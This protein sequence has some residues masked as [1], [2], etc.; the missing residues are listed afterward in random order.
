VRFAVHWP[1]NPV[2][3]PR[4]HGVPRRDVPSRVHIRIACVSAGHAAEQGLALAAARCD[5]PA[6]TT[7]LACERGIDFLHAAGGLVLQAAHQQPPGRSHNLPVQP[8]FGADVPPRLSDGASR[9][10]GHVTDIQVLDSDYVKPSSQVGRGLLGPVPPC[11]RIAGS[12]LRDG[13]LHP[14]TAIRAAPGSRQPAVE[15]TQPALP[16]RTGP[17]RSEHLPGRQ[18]RTDCDASVEANCLT[19][20]RRGNSLGD[21][22]EGYVP[23]SRTVHGDS[24]GLHA[25]RDCAGP[26][27][28]HPAGFRYPDLAGLA[29]EP[30]NMGGLDRDNTKTVVASGFPPGRPTVSASEQVHHGLGKVPQCL[31]LNHLGACTQ[32]LELGASLGELSAL[33]QVARSAATSGPPRGLL[34]DRE[35]PHEPGMRAGAF[36]HCFLDRS[37]FQAVPG[38]SNTISGSNDIP[39]E[40]KRRVLHGPKAVVSTPPS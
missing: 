20:A 17:G 27:E 7:T 18:R 37:R 29:A 40:V 21:R 24:V 15:T 32:P 33:L 4:S 28:S 8:G 26:A 22:G 11:I 30:S 5:V 3:F 38:H 25:F 16:R 2:A 39:E 19:R 1:G 13:Q 31:L 9:R 34:L 6:S 36:Q 23:A 12:E 35:V 14:S 10:A